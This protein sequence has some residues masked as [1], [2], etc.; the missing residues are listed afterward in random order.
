MNLV[1]AGIGSRKTP[2]PVLEAMTSMAFQLSQSKWHLRSGYAT[3]ADQAFGLGAAQQSEISN[4]DRWTM[5][6]PWAGFNNAPK[7]DSRFQ[8]AFPSDELF[9]IAREAHPAWDQLNQPAKL[10]M[11][12]NVM[13]V[14]GLDLGSPATCVI[15]W[16][17]D[18][19]RGGGTG[20]AM[21]VAEM[22]GIPVFDLAS[23]WDCR[24]VVEY[25]NG[26]EE[27]LHAI[28]NL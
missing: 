11:L 17:P 2:A 6:L 25:I 16:T 9:R 14:G 15:G 1:Y 3:G 22:L 8:V 10:L 21:R 18:A 13:I 4:Q 7:G 23:A 26:C 20:H 27:K 28:I 24:A 5:Y 12:R 19:R